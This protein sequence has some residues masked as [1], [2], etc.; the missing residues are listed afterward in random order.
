MCR[1]SMM[2]MSSRGG[3]GR[4]G[5]GGRG[6]RSGRGPRGRVGGGSG[7]RGNKNTRS[8]HGGRRQRSPPPPQPPP[9]QPGRECH[10]PCVTIGADVYVVKKDDQRTGRE[11][12]GEVSRLLTKSAYHPRGIKVMLTDGEVGRVTRFVRGNAAEE[13]EEAVVPRG[14]TDD[15][16]GGKK[17][18]R[19]L[20]DYLMEEGLDEILV[21]VVKAAADASSQV[22]NE[23]RHLSLVD[24]D[25]KEEGR[26]GGGK[27]INVQGEE[28]K[29]MDVRANAIFIEKLKPFV[30]AMVSEEEEGVIPGDAAGL[31]AKY[32]IAFDPLD[33]SSNLDVAAPTGS[34]FGI[35]RTRFQSSA[36]QSMVAAGYTVY[37]SATELVLA[38]LGG[39]NVA[40]FTLDAEDG[41]FRCSRPNV[42]CPQRGPYYSLN[43]AREPD[44]PDGLRRWIEDAKRGRTRAGIN[45]SARYVCSLTADVHRTLL[46]GGWAGNPRP[47]LR[48]LYE[49]APLAFIM[50]AAGGAGSD[51]VSDLL[52]VKPTSLHHRVC[53]FLGSKLDIEDLES[54]GNVQQSSKRYET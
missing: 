23:L 38:G 41:I 35:Y 27:N 20:S 10:R 37:S 31:S 9:G 18:K 42:V 15:D 48:L 26:G 54:Y 16:D 30:A 8:N 17:K 5:R 45:Y 34:I 47:H 50:E 14:R 40:S 7:G 28:Q 44:W 46:K 53:C 52:D 33:G 4:G 36:R 12:R 22:S 3:G 51:G 19:S 2:V 11:T 24:D 29:G 25:D 39:K 49:A 13:E 6:R 21:R 43:E 32:Y 1:L